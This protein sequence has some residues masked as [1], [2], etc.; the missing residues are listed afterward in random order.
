MSG[1]VVVVVVVDDNDGVLDDD[2]IVVGDDDENVVDDYDAVVLAV[3]VA[4]ALNKFSG[5]FIWCCYC[6]CCC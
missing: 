2:N 4:S 6:G 5:V 1:V 3:A